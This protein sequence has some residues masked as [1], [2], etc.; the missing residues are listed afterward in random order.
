MALGR[1]RHEPR[2]LAH[3]ILISGLLRELLVQG[4]LVDVSRGVPVVYTDLIGYDEAAHRRGP[5]A[6]VALRSL[7]SADGALAAIFAAADAVPELGYDVYVLSD[8]GHVATRPFEALVGVPFPEF[9]ARAERGE[10]PR[11]ARPNRG[12]AGGRTVGAARNDVVGVAEA[13]DLAHVY[14]LR[15]PGPLPL[16]ALRARHPRT[17][18]ALA[19]CPAVGLVGARGGRRGFALVRGAVLD[20]AEPRDVARLPHPQPA[21]AATYLSDLLSLRESG[22]L[23]VVGWRGEGR[24]VVAYAWEF[25]SHAGLAPEELEPFVVHPRD[26]AFRFDAIVR[27]SELF[28]FFEEAYRAPA[29]RDRPAADALAARGE[30][31]GAPPVP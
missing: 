6:R 20:L 16:E 21:L 13:G 3:R 18:A 12:V 24:D 29:G 19:A 15:E 10:A 5:D 27:P 1:L 31:A 28:R 9:V 25:G 17:L 8:H 30:A 14:F 7:A 22:D 26:A 4:I 23:V 2:F 11:P